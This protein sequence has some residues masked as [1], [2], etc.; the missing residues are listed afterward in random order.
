MAAVATAAYDMLRK[1]VPATIIT[2][3]TV[4]HRSR[5]SRRAT[6]VRAMHRIRPFPRALLRHRRKVG[7]D[8]TRGDS[9]VRRLARHRLLAAQAPPLALWLV[10]SLCVISTAFGNIGSSQTSITAAAPGLFA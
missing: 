1:F 7:V 10:Q 3:D 2:I 4:K 5:W 6:T 9:R 8:G